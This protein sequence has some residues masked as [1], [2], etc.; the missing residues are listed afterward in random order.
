MTISQSI[1]EY[2]PIIAYFIG[3]IVSLIMVWVKISNK[4][5]AIKTEITDI[6]KLSAKLEGRLDAINVP[7]GTLQTDMASVKTSLEFIKGS[8]N[9][10]GSAKPTL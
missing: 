5:E 1:V 8:I 4:V 9:Q 7:L 3:G 6:E 2:W 10:M